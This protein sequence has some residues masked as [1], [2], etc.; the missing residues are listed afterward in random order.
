MAKIWA[1]LTDHK[2]V[3]DMDLAALLMLSIEN[4]KAKKEII[5]K[6]GQIVSPDE[7][8]KVLDKLY[9]NETDPIGELF[10]KYREFDTIERKDEERIQ[11][12]IDRFVDLYK[13]L[14]QGHE[15][16]IPEEILCFKILEGARVDDHTKQLISSN[17]KEI[18]FDEVIAAFR[19]VTGFLSAPTRVIKQEP[20]EAVVESLYTNT[21]VVCYICG[22]TTHFQYQCLHNE[23]SH[24]HDHGGEEQ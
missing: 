8:F 1:G 20:E 14:E 13:E 10:R 7:L 18:K 24:L 22:D 5:N 4:K 21:D 6:K 19:K 15:M 12:Y 11:T 3:D 17:C 9:I 23:C 2:N 16:K